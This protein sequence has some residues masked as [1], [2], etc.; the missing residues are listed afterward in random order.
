MENDASFSLSPA[1]ADLLPC[2]CCII[3][4]ATARIL[5]IGHAA[6]AHRVSVKEEDAEDEV[7]LLECD[8]ESEA[9]HQH[10]LQQL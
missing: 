2:H 4:S 9:G 10:L 8:D 1:V 3:V 6:M 7:M 5:Q